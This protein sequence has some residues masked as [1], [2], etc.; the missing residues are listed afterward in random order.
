M[1]FSGMQIKTKSLCSNTH[2]DKGISI[3]GLTIKEQHKK[4]KGHVAFEETPGELRGSGIVLTDNGKQSVSLQD[5][6]P[7]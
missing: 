2:A 4:R 6:P 3:V 7:V 1:Q 5:Q